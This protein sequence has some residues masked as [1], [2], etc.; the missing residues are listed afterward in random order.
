M[1]TLTIKTR[2]IGPVEFYVAASGGYV[3]A[4]L[5]DQEGTLGR[6]ICDGGKTRGSTIR[7]DG[8]SLPSV[9]RAWNRARRRAILAEG[10]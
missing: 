8:A 10:R 4:D 2:D 1:T 9:A 7:A 5:N 6:Q 3:F